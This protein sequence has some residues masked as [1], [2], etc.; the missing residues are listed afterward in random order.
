MKFARRA[1]M[2]LS[3]SVL[4]TTQAR[5][6][7][8]HDLVVGDV[9][10]LDRST[11]V[12]C[13]PKDEAGSKL[14]NLVRNQHLAWRMH[15]LV[16]GESQT[17]LDEVVRCGMVSP[18]MVSPVAQ[19]KCGGKKSADDWLFSRFSDVQFE[20]VEMSDLAYRGYQYEFGLSKSGTERLKQ[21]CVNQ[22]YEAAVNVSIS[23][24]NGRGPLNPSDTSAR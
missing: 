24:A 8:V 2:F 13:V 14:R 19:F 17:V 5:A 15:T 1:L 10:M 4:F 21:I 16:V 18:E 23:I 6:E 12:T 11:V 3:L 7:S 20:R 22:G 9:L